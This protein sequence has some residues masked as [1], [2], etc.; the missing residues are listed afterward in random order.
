M[1]DE[2]KEMYE[3][4]GIRES[5]RKFGQEALSGLKERFEKIDEVADNCY[6]RIYV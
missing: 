1:F 4:M 3:H 2:I 5:V 6:A